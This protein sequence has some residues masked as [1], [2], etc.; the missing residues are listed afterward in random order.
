[1]AS[2]ERPRTAFAFCDTRTGKRVGM[3][4]FMTHKQAEDEYDYFL[5]RWAKGGRPDLH[6]QLL[7]MSI[8]EIAIGAWGTRPGDW[9]THPT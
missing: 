8:V 5:E 6:E 2:D 4:S 7:F 3:S 1:M 9:I